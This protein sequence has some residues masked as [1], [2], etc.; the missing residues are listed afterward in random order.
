MKSLRNFYMT[1]NIF[2][3]RTTRFKVIRKKLC[4]RVK[5]KK[6]IE[7]FKDFLIGNLS[8]IK[9]NPEFDIIYVPLSLNEFKYRF[10]Y[11]RKN[12]NL[13]E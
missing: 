11:C 5:E 2:L 6:C 8:G 4:D 13:C 9:T 12:I 3:V 7:K 1:R 10:G